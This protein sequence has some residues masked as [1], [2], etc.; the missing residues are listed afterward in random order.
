MTSDKAQRHE[1]ECR[2]SELLREVAS[3][4]RAPNTRLL[5]HSSHPSSC[6]RSLRQSELPTRGRFGTRLVR[7]LA[8]GHFGTLS[9]QHE[10]AS[11]LV[12][13]ELLRE[14]T[15]ALRAPNTRSLRHSSH[16]SSC[17]RSL[18]HS[19]LP[20]RGRFGTPHP[21][22]C[23]RSLW[24]SELPTRGR[25]GILPI[26]PQVCFGTHLNNPSPKARTTLCS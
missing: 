5:R 3:A 4:L 8:R 9:S 15:S 13:S 26:R 14:V 25:F 22:S 10:V 16:L 6:A 17:A 24:H 7:A 20:T 1:H 2:K 12:S 21:S 23:A 19:E 18:Q 11:A